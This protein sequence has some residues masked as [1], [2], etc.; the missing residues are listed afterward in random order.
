MAK[1]YD[2][3]YMTSSSSGTPFSTSSVT[4]Y[5]DFQ[6]F[7]AQDET[8]IASFR[9]GSNN[10]A[11]GWCR[12]D[13][14]NNV[15]VDEY[16]FTST[17]PEDNTEPTFSGTVDIVVGA[18]S[19]NT[20]AYQPTGGDGFGGGSSYKS[21]RVPHWL[22]RSPTNTFTSSAN[23]IHWAEFM[24]METGWFY[25]LFVLEKS[26]SSNNYR[27]GLYSIGN[28]GLPSGI[29]A[30]SGSVAHTGSGGSTDFNN[31][32][33]ITNITQANPAVV[34]Y[35][36]TDPS[37]GDRIYITDVVG[38]TQ[39]NDR[40]FIVANVNTGSNTLELKGEDST[41]HTAYSSAGTVHF[42]IFMTPGMYLYALAADGANTF[43]GNSGSQKDPAGWLRTRNSLGTDP[44]HA[45]SGHTYA[46]LPN[47][48][49][50]LSF[51][52][53]VV[54]ATALIKCEG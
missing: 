22:S 35:T 20:F 1:N 9:D 8:F 33:T 11:T 15:V 23:T 21:Y 12:L 50:G 5:N 32:L 52:T 36:G 24:L 26:G 46:A 49:T 53:A 31:T 27:L 42:P 13:G 28:D 44:N 3:V 29:I 38:M 34:T 17:G 48:E 54:Y 4:G 14:S 39:V 37:N 18:S 41:S 10:Y 25:N 19:V 43:T 7:Y 51:T 30:E 40:S 6:D 47:T 45:T 2:L 16:L